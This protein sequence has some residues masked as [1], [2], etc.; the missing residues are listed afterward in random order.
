MKKVGSRFD[1]EYIKAD[2]VM[3]WDEAFIA[4]S[5]APELNSVMDMSGFLMPID[6]LFKKFGFDIDAMNI[7]YDVFPRKNKSE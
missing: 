2:K 4:S 7:T 3:P 5:I 1:G 6:E